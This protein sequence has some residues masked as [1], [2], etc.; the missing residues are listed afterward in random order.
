MSVALSTLQY[1]PNR[2]DDSG[3]MTLAGS[4]KTTALIQPSSGAAPTAGNATLVGGTVTVNTTAVVT[5]DIVLLT[6]KTSGGTI[7]TAITYTINSGVSFT[8]TSD[9]VLDTSEFSWAIVKVY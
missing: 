4:A 6:R 8:I 3:N 2:L 7:G 9:N 5:G 1:M